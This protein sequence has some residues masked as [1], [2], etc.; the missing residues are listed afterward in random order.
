M[1]QTQMAMLNGLRGQLP[2]PV[3]DAFLGMLGQCAAELSH[4]GPTSIDVHPDRLRDA[5]CKRISEEDGPA[6]GL[7][8]AAYAGQYTRDPDMA[9]EGVM[10]GPVAIFTQ[11][12][13]YARPNEDNFSFIGKCVDVECIYAD[14]VTVNHLTVTEGIEAMTALWVVAQ[15]NWKYSAFYPSKGGGMAWVTVLQCADSAGSS[16]TGSEFDVW[17]PVGSGQ[18]PN[19]VEGQVF[20]VQKASSEEWVSESSGDDAI[21][22]VKF[23]AGTTAPG[24]FDEVLPGWRVVKRIPG[25]INPTRSGTVWTLH[26]SYVFTWPVATDVA[27]NLFNLEG[28]EQHTHAPHTPENGSIED[29]VL[30][31]F[32]DLAYTD[33]TVAQDSSYTGRA[34]TGI[35]LDP[36]PPH[37]HDFA[38]TTFAEEGSDLNVG[39]DTSPVDT[40]GPLDEDGYAV[41]LDHEVYDPG[42][43]HFIWGYDP[44]VYDP[45]HY[46]LFGTTLEHDWY[47]PHEP[48]EHIPPYVALFLIER[49]D[50]GLSGSTFAGGDP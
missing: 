4:R 24:S 2:D 21:G 6:S 7:H 22:S 34:A 31:V 47:L 5:P 9:G 1:F 48:A 35:Y 41:V 26:P 23:W 10:C 27:S 38:L 39:V 12:P 13:I 3:I 46:H 11:G 49:V 33:I 18:D 25:T 42:H 29:H 50:N 45:G 36:H 43:E 44:D 37:Y 28:A 32:T 15:T 30:L 20:I 17:L 8:V 19:I 40:T 14:S 16:P